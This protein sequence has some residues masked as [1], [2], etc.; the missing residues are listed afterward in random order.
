MQCVIR[1]RLPESQHGKVGFI[2]NWADL[3]EIQP[4]HR[5]TNPLINELGIHDRFIVLFAGNIGRVQG[6][7]S[8]IEAATQLLEHPEICLL[9]IGSGALEPLL[10]QEIDKRNLRNILLLPSQPRERQNIFLNA[11]DI[12]LLS[13]S[14]NMLGMGVPS[15]LYNYMAAGKPVIGAVEMESEPGRVINEEQIGWIV[16]PGDPIILADVIIQ[17]SKSPLLSEMG[18]RARAAALQHYSQKRIVSM[19]AELADAL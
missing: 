17:A 4:H 8:I 5:S 6:I 13:L 14:Q 12:T 19:Y 3:E 16:P 10:R 15:R 18:N 7:P 11:C 1:Q 9:F 2:P